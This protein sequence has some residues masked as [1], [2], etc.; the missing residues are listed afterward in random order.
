MELTASHVAIQIR[1]QT[2]LKGFALTFLQYDSKRFAPLEPARHLSSRGYDKAVQ[3]IYVSGSRVLFQPLEVKIFFGARDS[4]AA[5]ILV[6]KN[7]EHNNFRKDVHQLSAMLLRSSPFPDLYHSISIAPSHRQCCRMTM[8]V[9]GDSSHC[10]EVS[11]RRKD[12]SR[13]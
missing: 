12:L 11:M 8:R 2:P 6:S 7:L 10:P 9:H 5:K 1:P 3:H 4:F 13:I